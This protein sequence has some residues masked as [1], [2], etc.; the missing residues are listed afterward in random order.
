MKMVPLLFLDTNVILDFILR[1]PGWEDVARIIDL[2]KRHEVRAYCSYLTMA[3]IAYI[4]RKGNAPDMVRTIIGSI[5][6]WCEVLAPSSMDIHAATRMN[7]PDFEDALQI[8]CAESKPNCIIVTRNVKHF[9]GYTE[10]PVISLGDP[11]LFGRPA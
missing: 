8:I 7:H 4:V 5:T 6:S 2:S 9:E 1:R 10:Q 11:R 3:D